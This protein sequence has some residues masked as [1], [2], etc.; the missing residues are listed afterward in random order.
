MYTKLFKLLALLVSITI[1]VSCSE[2]D[3]KSYIS[4]RSARLALTP[5]PEIQA[6]VDYSPNVRPSDFLSRVSTIE[7]E[8]QT[9]PTLQMVLTKAD[10]GTLVVEST[11]TSPTYSKDSLFYYPLIPPTP[12]GVSNYCTEDI[13]LIENLEQAL[14]FEVEPIIE[15]L[16]ET[17]AK[18]VY[19]EVLSYLKSLC[20]SQFRKL[21]ALK[22]SVSELGDS[23][24]TEEL[25]IKAFTYAKEND[26][27]VT[28]AYMLA[29]HSTPF[30]I[31]GKS[32]EVPKTH[33]ELINYVKEQ[34]SLVKAQGDFM[35]QNVG[36]VD[37]IAV[38]YQRQHAQRT[39]LRLSEDVRSEL[40]VCKAVYEELQATNTVS[41]DVYNKVSDQAPRI[42]SINA[43][44]LSLAYHLDKYSPV[45]PLWARDQTRDPFIVGTP[46]GYG[47][48]MLDP[49]KELE[50][51][52][53][54]VVLKRAEEGDKDAERALLVQRIAVSVLEHRERT[55]THAASKFFTVLECRAISSLSKT[56]TIVDPNADFSTNEVESD[57]EE[58]A[59]PSTPVVTPVTNTPVRRLAE[60]ASELID[61]ED[62]D[63][64]PEIVEAVEVVETEPCTEDP[65]VILESLAQGKLNYEPA[66][67]ASLACLAGPSCITNRDGSPKICYKPVCVNKDCS[68]VAIHKVDCSEATCEH[69]NCKPGSCVGGKCDIGRCVGGKFQSGSCSSTRCVGCTTELP[70]VEGCDVRPPHCE[71]GACAPSR[72]RGAKC[73]KQEFL[74]DY[75]CAKGECKRQDCE[76]C[77]SSGGAGAAGGSDECVAPTCVPGSCT[78]GSCHS[79]SCIPNNRPDDHCVHGSCT[80]GYCIG[81]KC[82]ADEYDGFRCKAPKCTPARCNSSCSDCTC[83]PASCTTCGCVPPKCVG[84]SCGRIQCCGCA[85]VRCRGVKVVP[86]RIVG[87]DGR[88]VGSCQNSSCAGYNCCTSSNVS[89]SPGSSGDYYPT[90]PV[91]STTTRAT[92]RPITTTTTVG[93]STVRPTTTTTRV[94]IITRPIT[95]TTT[96]TRMT[97]TTTTT[98]MTTTT[99]TTRTTTTTTTRMTTTTTT[100]RTTT[101]TTTTRA[102]TTTTTRMTTTTTTTRTTTTTTTTRM[103]TTTTTTRM[104]TTTTTTRMTT[105]TTTTRMTTT[106]TT[107][108]MTT[109]TTTT[110]TGG[111]TKAVFL[112]TSS[113]STTTIQTRFGRSLAQVPGPVVPE[114]TRPESG[115]PESGKPESGK[116]ESG[117]PESGKP[118]SG[119]PESGKPES[120]KPESGKSCTCVCSGSDS[121]KCAGCGT[122]NSGKS[123]CSS[124]CMLASGCASSCCGGGSAMSPTAAAAEA[125]KQVE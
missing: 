66:Q 18:R 24:I 124:G 48:V 76:T 91:T 67:C 7:P 93:V 98:R 52:Y 101:T 19:E 57:V 4:P 85:P 119:K 64:I 65:E 73:V 112:R 9:T 34:C 68:H 16:P 53:N 47:V 121:S 54:N 41:E 12:S 115:K 111:S 55:T 1:L 84:G 3:K 74:E 86:A 45:L 15:S 39:Y 59:G 108:R 113:T 83:T 43:G 20:K 49:S 50:D 77:G 63:E 94:T 13:K 70:R 42:D 69:G 100:T 30:P 92:I 102:T 56:T 117:K 122:C 46:E 75:H 123:C 38:L 10:D 81:P 35:E 89:E 78:T 2:N 26:I 17:E 40:E 37:K 31:P 58:A 23:Q 90:I 11:G 109:T 62:D 110:T 29:A 99:T 88:A 72:I 103:T 8:Q 80:G 27:L 60:A 44:T 25:V 107:T 118:E 82:S 87:R 36:R 106:T 114:S 125:E 97:T 51:Y 120:G 14:I 61:E 33:E 32:P 79:G 22:Q 95:T 104:T 116:Q 71:E 96:T 6:G 28:T 105:T 21:H 5:E